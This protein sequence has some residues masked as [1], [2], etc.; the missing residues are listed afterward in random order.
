MIEIS[1]SE[2]RQDDIGK[3]VI[4]LHDGGT[5]EGT[6]DSAWSSWEK[7]AKPEPGPRCRLVVIEGSVEVQ[8]RHLPMDFRLQIEHGTDPGATHE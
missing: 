6:L 4:V 8:V 3:R 5:I 2:L 7:Y 1:L